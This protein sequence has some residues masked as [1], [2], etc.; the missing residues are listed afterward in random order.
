MEKA[1]APHSSTPAWRI[2]W[3][4]EP[5]RLQSM[6][7]QRVGHDWAT[8]LSFS[9]LWKKCI[10]Y[11]IL[12]KCDSRRTVNLNVKDKKKNIRGKKIHEHLSDFAAVKI[13]KAGIKNPNMEENSIQETIIQVRTTYSKTR[14]ESERVLV[15]LVSDKGLI[16]IWK[17]SS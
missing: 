17:A 1:I 4:E 10:E 8:S 6:G 7:L 11:N 14:L 5:S 12:K 9:F 2:P 13:I 15:V 16:L 3:M